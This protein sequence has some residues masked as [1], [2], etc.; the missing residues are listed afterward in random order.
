M[1][2]AERVT[3]AFITPCGFNYIITSDKCRS[4]EP[5]FFHR[6]SFWKEDIIFQ[7]DVEVQV[8][9]KL[10]QESIG[11]AIRIAG[12]FRGIKSVRKF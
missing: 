5:F 7:V 3:A 6:Q 11:H 12:I 8:I 10:P 1:R 4:I 9:F 2:N